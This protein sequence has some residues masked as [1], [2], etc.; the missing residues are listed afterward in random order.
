[1][2]AAE[3]GDGRRR[4]GPRLR[5]QPAA[6]VPSY[7]PGVVQLGNPVIVDAPG[8]PLGAADATRRHAL[9]LPDGRVRFPGVTA[10]EGTRT[11]AVLAGLGPEG[12]DR[13]LL[14]VALPVLLSGG[15]GPHLVDAEGRLVLAVAEHPRLAGARIAMG[16]S[17][18][19]PGGGG[20]EVV[21]LVR[22]AGP[23]VWTWSV[24]A[25]VPPDGR[26]AAL[27]DLDAARDE[28]DLGAWR[29]RWE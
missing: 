5:R 10:P 26:N 7:R 20:G 2:L 23:G 17:A 15:A 3:D 13:A 19:L 9:L 4:A 14:E 6:S 22:R 21:G 18:G 16:P 12:W 28:A 25:L 29:A 8:A 27:D 24:R 11:A 1:M